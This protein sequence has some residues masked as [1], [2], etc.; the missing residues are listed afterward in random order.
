M[1]LRA[2]RN[3][4]IVRVRYAEKS[5]GGIVIP[6]KAKQYNGSFVGDVHSVG[7]EYKYDVKVGDC[8]HFVRHE[9]HRIRWQGKAYLSLRAKWVVSREKIV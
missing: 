3:T 2:V 4:I 6:D 8:V 9:G 1:S 7:P 5:E